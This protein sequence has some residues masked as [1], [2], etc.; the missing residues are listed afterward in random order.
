MTRGYSGELEW[1]AHHAKVKRLEA[2]GGGTFP[3]P[4]SAPQGLVLQSALK[5]RGWG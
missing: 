3:L 2:M 5:T 4:L 1:E